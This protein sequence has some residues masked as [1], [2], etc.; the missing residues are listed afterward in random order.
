MNRAF[1][2]LFSLSFFLIRIAGQ[3]IL[4]IIARGFTSQSIMN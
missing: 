1:E 4:C 3:V 2:D